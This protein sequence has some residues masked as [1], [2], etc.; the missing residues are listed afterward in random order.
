MA[1]VDI[2]ALP[3]LES[4]GAVYRDNGIVGNAVDIFRDN[5]VNWVR[6]RMFVDPIGQDP[7]AVQDLDYTIQ[8]AQRVKSAGAKLLLDFH[9]S[10]TWADPGKQYK[11]AAWQSLNFTQLQQQVYDYTRSSIES[12]KAAGVLPEMVQIG[13]EISSGMIWDDGRLWRA[14]VSENTEFNNLAALLSAGINGARD[15]AG[16][17]QEPLI[18]I[19]HDQGG[20]WRSTSYW[21]DRLLPRLQNNGTDVDVI[22][23]SYY[24]K[25]HYNPSNGN[26]D[27]TDVQTNLDNTAASYNKPVVI[28]EAGFASRGAQ[29]EPD[30]QFEV[31]EEG[32]QEYLQAVVDA[33]RNVP[34]DRGWGVFWWYAEAQPTLGVSV[35][36]NGRYGLFDGNG[37]ALP[38]LDVFNTLNV[39]GDYNGDGVVDQQD[40]S[41]WKVTYGQSVNSLP[42]D[43]DDDGDVDGVDFLVWQ[44]HVGAASATASPIMAIPEPISLSLC[45]GT[46]LFIAILLKH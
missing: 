31:S 44:R 30:Y 9:Y 35:W 12:F 16:P 20:S 36:E 19:H 8:L 22:G 23:Y 33:V 26:G 14:G 46:G 27:M 17:G 10:D 7:V 38:A 24:P 37:N 42:A 13:N 32:Q 1:G 41:V 3:V 11:P 4:H 21:L 6:L 45:I 29:F 34:N 25:W 40:L 18:M 15:G 5:G 2:S 43:G 28:V 39:P